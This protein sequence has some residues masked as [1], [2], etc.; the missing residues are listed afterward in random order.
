MKNSTIKPSYLITLIAPID[1]G[2]FQSVDIDRAKIKSI[3]RDS[4]SLSKNFSANP[5]LL[6]WEMRGGGGD[7]PDKRVNERTVAFGQ[8]RQ[9]TFSEN[10]LISKYFYLIDFG[11]YFID[12]G[13]ILS[14]SVDFLANKLSPK[15]QEVGDLS[16]KG[17]SA[18]ADFDPVNGRKSESQTVGNTNCRPHTGASRLSPTQCFG[19]NI[20]YLPKFQTS[21]NFCVSSWNFHVLNIS[22]FLSGKSQALSE[23]R[24]RFHFST[25]HY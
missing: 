7:F 23:C 16:P 14:I 12:F 9:F 6:K 2:R 4:H 17:R 22:N 25:L 20:A 1:F 5:S 13:R 8:F 10:V 21:H 15:S 3:F 18:L 24:L 11:H 19:R